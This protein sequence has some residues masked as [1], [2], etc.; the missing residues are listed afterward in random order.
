MCTYSSIAEYLKNKFKHKPFCIDVLGPD[1]YKYI[2]ERNK[3]Q[4]GLVLN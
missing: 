3:H 4:A 1:F 2:K